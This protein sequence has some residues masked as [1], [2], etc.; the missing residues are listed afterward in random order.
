[1]AH[2]FHIY[3]YICCSCYSKIYSNLEDICHPAL[4][5]VSKTSFVDVPN[6]LHFK[7]LKVNYF[8]LY[9][10]LTDVDICAIGKRCVQQGSH[11]KPLQMSTLFDTTLP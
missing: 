4:S 9:M 11:C 7:D 2:I 8:Y 1:M 3:I 10:G 6:L 5:L